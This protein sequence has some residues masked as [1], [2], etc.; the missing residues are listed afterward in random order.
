MMPSESDKLFM[1]L[2]IELAYTAYEN[3]EVPVGA[4]VVQNR[5]S[6]ILAAFSN[7]MRGT[8]S[9]LAHA[10]MLALQK[11]MEVLNNERLVGCNMYVSLEPCPM[12]AQAISFARIDT[13]FYAADDKKSGGVLSGPKIYESTSCHHKPKVIHGMMQKESSDL[14]KKFFKARR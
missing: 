7:Q 2:A 5:N 6:E 13:L 9:S 3:N 10:E 11:S 12:C 8:G 14:L 4:V 1:G